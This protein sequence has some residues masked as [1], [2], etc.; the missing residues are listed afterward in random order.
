MAIEY[1]GYVLESG[2]IIFDGEAAELAE[3]ECLVSAYL[4]QTRGD[5]A[6]RIFSDERPIDSRRHCRLRL[7]AG[8]ARTT[9]ARRSVK[10][11][12]DVEQGVVPVDDLL[13]QGEIGG[14]RLLRVLLAAM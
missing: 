12:L 10:L 9:I 11:V 13:S 4:G 7:S 2:G 8:W 14:A 3:H 6:I 5:E 1:R